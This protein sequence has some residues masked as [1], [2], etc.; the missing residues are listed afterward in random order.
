MKKAFSQQWR[1]A[2]LVVAGALIYGLAQ[3]SE[4]PLRSHLSWARIFNHDERAAQLAEKLQLMGYAVE[5]TARFEDLLAFIDEA[6]Q[7]YGIEKEI[8]LSVALVE[9]GLNPQGLSEKGA[10]GIFQ[11]RPE[12]ADA[13]WSE[14]SQGFEGNDS[15]MH[16]KWST[17]LHDPRL[18]TLL[19]AFYL[20]KLKGQFKNRLHLAL[21]AYNVGPG[22]LRRAMDQGELKGTEY[23]FRVY[24]IRNALKGV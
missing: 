10:R 5:D 17:S 3:F 19:G 4:M 11:I 15:V 18:S 20:S 22:K 12:T 8:L 7:K 6:S 9:S 13:I 14:F 1:V 2:I 21:A 16:G 24:Q 23:I